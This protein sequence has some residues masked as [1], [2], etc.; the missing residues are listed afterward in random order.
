MA[1]KE[2]A[3]SKFIYD[4]AAAEHGQRYEYIQLSA[5]YYLLHQSYTIL[6]LLLFLHLIIIGGNQ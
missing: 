1:R 5:M 4:W 6:I 2:Y 3:D